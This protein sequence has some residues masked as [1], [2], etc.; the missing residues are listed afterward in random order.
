MELGPAHV[1]QGRRSTRPGDVSS[2]DRGLRASPGRGCG[3]PGGR[4]C[5]EGRPASDTRRPGSGLTCACYPSPP[6]C[7]VLNEPA[8]WHRAK[9]S[10][11][12]L[13]QG[14]ARNR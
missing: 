14:R 13:A 11:Y 12:G 9:D 8:L 10:G 2:T 5:A 6:S 1:S 7:P 4:L 3:L